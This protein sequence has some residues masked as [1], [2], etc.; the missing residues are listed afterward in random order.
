MN[1]SYTTPATAR[2]AAFVAAFLTSVVVLGST[3][4]GMQPHD[5]ASASLVALQ[6]A[7]VNATAVR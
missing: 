4:V 2:I 1:A 3:V 5:D 7:T 6:R